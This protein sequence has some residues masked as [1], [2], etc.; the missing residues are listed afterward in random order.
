MRIS[1][2]LRQKPQGDVISVN[3]KATVADAAQ[4]M[5]AH[6][7]GAVVVRGDENQ[8]EGILSERDIVRELGQRDSACLSDPVATLMTRK[9]VTCSPDDTALTALEMMT[10][11]R[12]R[13]LPVLDK[14]QMIGLISIGDAVK[15]RL[16]ELSQENQ[17][18]EGM[19]A[20]H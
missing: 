16:D 10:K 6:R 8:L 7:I 1:Q 4:L 13:H 9:L 18:L 19:I 11:G 2:M 15:A 20:G 14:G 17:A 5:S 12:F 3:P